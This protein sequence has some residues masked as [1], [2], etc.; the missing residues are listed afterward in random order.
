MK[1]RL[2]KNIFW[3]LFATGTLFILF[4]A[5]HT[6]YNR[7][8]V[9][10]SSRLE[11][12]NHLMKDL[13]TFNYRALEFNTLYENE[14][15]K[16]DSVTFRNHYK[17]IEDSLHRAHEL[18]V[19]YA[20]FNP[21]FVDSINEL[22][23]GY[24][25]VI[26]FERELID[27]RVRI[28]A[29]KKVLEYRVFK[30][31]AIQEALEESVEALEGMGRAEL[32]TAEARMRELNDQYFRVNLFYAFICLFVFIFL[33]VQVRAESRKRSALEFRLKDY[34]LELFKELKEKSDQLNELFD[35]ISDGYFVLNKEGKCIHVNTQGT[36]IVGK[37]KEE[38]LGK[39]YHELYKPKSELPVSMKFAPA[40]EANLSTHNMVFDE[41]SQKWLEFYAYPFENGMSIFIRD[42]TE[43]IMSRDELIRGNER[44]QVMNEQLRNLSEHLQRAREDERTFIAKE[45]HDEL[46]Q[47]LT[48]IKLDLAWIKS[49]GHE[50]SPDLLDRLQ[51]AVDLTNVAITTVK[52]I[53][54][55]LRPV[56]LDD[57]G[58]S[59]A[60]EWQCKN[61]AAKNNLQLNLV[62]GVGDLHF[63]KDLSTTVFRICQEALTNITRHSKASAIDVRFDWKDGV[64]CLRVADN[65]IG[66]LREMKS[67]SFGIV[68]MI[69]RAES[70]GGT[71]ELEENDPQGVVLTLKVPYDEDTHS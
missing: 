44:L 67:G 50:F 7:Q 33:I 11:Q 62:I 38:I 13:E 64:L 70:L 69:E 68:G 58:L 24:G 56:I 46:G 17:A 6:W 71:L 34:N 8:N 41:L 25:A 39:Y 35:R 40:M 37:S 66:G 10:W 51:A 19:D 22:S 23:F 4:A 36:L 61:S 31:E 1:Q 9:K 27:N 3:G 48:G 52:R 55:N 14:F 57:F 29:N 16:V 2:N 54:T 43:L 26:R 32:R 47:T 5:I 59:A 53:A 20:K 12:T 45:I 15:G 18:I 60:I 28:P 30:L 42:V 65:G 21:V 63:G 49:K